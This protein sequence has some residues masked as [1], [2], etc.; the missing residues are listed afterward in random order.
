M[1]NNVSH[2]TILL[3]NQTKPNQI[4]QTMNKQTQSFRMIAIARPIKSPALSHYSSF[5]NVNLFIL[6]IF[7]NKVNRNNVERHIHCDII[8]AEMKKKTLLL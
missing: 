7:S 2:K 6:S 5:T 3:I 4:K 1:M 8:E